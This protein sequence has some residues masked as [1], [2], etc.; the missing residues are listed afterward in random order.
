MS[1]KTFLKENLLPILSDSSRS[2]NWSLSRRA[3]SDMAPRWCDRC[4]FPVK[5][6]GDPTAPPRCPGR[7]ENASACPETAGDCSLVYSS[8]WP[9]VLRNRSSRFDP[10]WILLIS[11][12]AGTEFS[13]S[14]E[15]VLHRGCLPVHQGLVLDAFR[16]LRRSR[17]AIP[18]FEGLIGDLAF[19]QELGELPPLCLTLE[20]HFLSRSP[21]VRAHREGG[22]TS[23]QM[24]ITHFHTPPGSLRQTVTALPSIA[25]CFP[26]APLK[27][28]RFVPVA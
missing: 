15:C 22:E 2:T 8:S 25:T 4:G 11:G 3:T 28:T 16:K 10:V 26:S 27:V 6:W 24:S 21:N 12:S 9:S 1:E 19:D 17:L 5:T 14:L 20:W 23:F 13:A 7:A 18:F